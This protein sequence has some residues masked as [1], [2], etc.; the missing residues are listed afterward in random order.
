MPPLAVIPTC[1]D[2]DRFHRKW[3]RRVSPLC[4]AMWFRWD[5]VSVDEIVTFYSHLPN[6]VPTRVCFSSI[7]MST[8]S[9]RDRLRDAV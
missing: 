8:I 9:S 7:A 4:L 2:L 5:L 3:K 1:A 6:G